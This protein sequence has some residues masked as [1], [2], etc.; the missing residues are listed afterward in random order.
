LKSDMS[1]KYSPVC[2][3]TKYFQPPM[4]FRFISNGT[5]I[6]MAWVLTRGLASHT[7]GKNTHLD[8]SGYVM[9]TGVYELG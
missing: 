1:W 7:C 6:A 3:G 9:H 8:W 5:S 4:I 2:P